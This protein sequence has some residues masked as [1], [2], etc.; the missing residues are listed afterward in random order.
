MAA[1]D[2]YLLLVLIAYALIFLGLGYILF[3]VYRE[4]TRKVRKLR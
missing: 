1:S 3:R 4:K 2:P